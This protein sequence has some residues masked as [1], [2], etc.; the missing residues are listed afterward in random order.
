MMNDDKIKP[1]ITDMTKIMLTLGQELV[2]MDEMREIKRREWTTTIVDET[3]E[4]KIRGVIEAITCKK[5]I[6]T[7]MFTGGK[8]TESVVT[9]VNDTIGM[10]IAQILGTITRDLVVKDVTGMMIAQILGTTTQGLVKDV[11][12]MMIAQIL[13]TITKGLAETGMTLMITDDN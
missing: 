5:N 2:I 13:G 10:M 6:E 8:R 1:G 3:K 12:G 7:S 9:M 4:I 11:I